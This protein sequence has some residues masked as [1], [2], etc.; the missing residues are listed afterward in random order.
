MKEKT[1]YNNLILFCVLQMSLVSVHPTT[2]WNLQQDW[3]NTIGENKKLFSFFSF[4]VYWNILGI[5]PQMLLDAT[6]KL[7]IGWTYNFQ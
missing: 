7:K 6:Q 2:C 5:W 4:S 1:Q 3:Y